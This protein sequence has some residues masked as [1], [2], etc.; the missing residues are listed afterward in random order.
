[1]IY[2]VEEVSYLLAHYWIQV[3][4]SMLFRDFL[5]ELNLSP[6]TSILDKLFFQKYGMMAH[7]HIVIL[8]KIEVVSHSFFRISYKM[9]S[10][11]PSL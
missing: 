7:N 11:G 2:E 10:K 1:M 3:L 5:F 6:T 9:S 8:R 4:D